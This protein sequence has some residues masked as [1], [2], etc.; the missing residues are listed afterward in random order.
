MD[1]IKIAIDDMSDTD[2]P[3]I[4]I[5]YHFRFTFSDQDK[6]LKCLED[7]QFIGRCRLIWRSLINKLSDNQY[8]E[9][10]KFTSGFEVRNKAGDHC[11]AHIHIAFKSTH[12][13]QSMNRTIK[14]LLTEEFDQLYLGNK[15]YSFKE[16]HVRNE[17][18]FWRYPLKQ[19][20][21][22]QMCRGFQKD[23]LEQMHKVASESYQKVCQVHQS[24]MDNKDNSD[25]LFQRVLSICKKNN[26][27]SKRAIAKTFY[28][29]YL[30]E[31]KPI[32]RQ[33]IEGYVLNASIKLNLMTL[34]QLLD[35]HGY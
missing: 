35:T 18:E 20:L 7:N 33:V 11:K 5:A 23:R 8:F 14:R 16:Q 29:Y 3:L 12:I 2:T 31:N 34:D 19:G 1:N 28:S 22:L 24:K 30:E 6:D 17:E 15:C 13:K 9:K 32:N 25:T 21:N 27:N 26:D 4:P 10:D